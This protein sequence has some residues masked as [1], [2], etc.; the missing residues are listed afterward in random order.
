MSKKLTKK[1]LCSKTD[2]DILNEA[3]ANYQ[4]NLSRDGICNYYFVCKDKKKLWNKLNK[5]VKV[6]LYKDLHYIRCSVAVY[7][8]NR[9]KR[10]VSSEDSFNIDEAVEVTKDNM[11]GGA[12]KSSDVTIL[13]ITNSFEFKRKA[14]KILSV[15]EKLESNSRSFV[16]QS[17]ID[18]KKVINNSKKETSSESSE[19][20]ESDNDTSSS[21]EVIEVKDKS[22]KTHYITD[23]LK[24]I[25]IDSDGE[26]VIVGGLIRCTNKKNYDI[27]YEGI[28]YKI[29]LETS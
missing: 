20:S 6:Y 15:L 3:E 29:N 12:T 8:N 7:V 4:T 1:S 16:A 28:K 5:D 10:H 25:N 2:E 19:S 17:I 18:E 24:L 14:D 23:D 9:C 13:G 22:G 21:Y 11:D 26:G 27:I